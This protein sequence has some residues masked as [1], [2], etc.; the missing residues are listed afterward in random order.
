MI[1]Y[2]NNKYNSRSK[3]LNI[4]IQSV[5]PKRLPLTKENKS[6]LKSLKLRLKKL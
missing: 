4:P 2:N 5:K 1:L 6:F 3:N